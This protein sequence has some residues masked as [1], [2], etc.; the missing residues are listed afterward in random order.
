MKKAYVFPDLAVTL[1]CGLAASRSGWIPSSSN[2]PL[3]AGVCSSFKDASLSLFYRALLSSC[4]DFGP[5]VHE[6]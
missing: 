1:V 5:I 6:T 2:D 4:L 3:R